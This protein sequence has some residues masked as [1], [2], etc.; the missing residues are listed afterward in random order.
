MDVNFMLNFFLANIVI[1]L[2]E[3]CSRTEF[4]S[5]YLTMLKG[6]SNKTNSHQAGELKLIKTLKNASNNTEFWSNQIPRIEDQTVFQLLNTIPVS[7]KNTYAQGF[8]DQVTV[9]NNT[10]DWQYL[11][12]A[13]TTGRM[14]VV[15]DFEKRDYLRAAEHLNLKLATGSALGYKSV[16]IPPSACNVVCGFADQGPEPIFKFFYWALKNNR[17]FTG[18]TLSDLRGRFERQIMLKREV[19][20]PINSVPWEKMCEQLDIYLDN[21]IEDKVSIIRALPHFLLWLAKRAEQRNLVF[22]DVKTLLPYG[23]LAGEELVKTITSI[24]QAKFI[25]VYGTGEIGSIGCAVSDPHIVE[26]YS[27]MVCLEVIDES[28]KY[29]ALNTPGRVVVTDLNNFA[30]P[31]IRYEIGDV[32]EVIKYDERN[33]LPKKIKILGRKQECLD[34]PSGKC[35]TPLEIQDVFLK[36]PNVINFKLE[37]ITSKIFK[38]SIVCL[39]EVDTK[40]LSGNIQRLL[41]L[42]KPPSI[43]INE[44]I[45]PEQSGKFLSVKIIKKRDLG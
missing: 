42:S 17:L 6:F 36:F 26:V 14:T 7:Q 2:F 43:K 32:A 19:L 8:P 13:G 21:I 5:L 34:L 12:S 3:K 41:E 24:F 45:I 35:I 15:V 37:Q 1:P 16:D 23:G 30:M 31:I 27:E 40:T 38:I 18:A 20:M 33:G 4:W 11:S 9:K 25:N 39:N 28:G 29:V 10:D 22:P 44:F